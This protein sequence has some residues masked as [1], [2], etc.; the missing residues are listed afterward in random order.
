LVLISFR[1][2]TTESMKSSMASLVS[3]CSARKHGR[4]GSDGWGVPV[5]VEWGLGGVETMAY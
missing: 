5:V 4:I 1:I 3:A 2:L